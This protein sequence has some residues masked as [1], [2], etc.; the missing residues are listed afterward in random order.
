MSA[1][2]IDLQHYEAVVR[3]N[4]IRPGENWPSYVE[5]ICVIAGG[6]QPG[7]GFLS[8]DT[9]WFDW[10]QTPA[11]GEPPESEPPFRYSETGARLPYRD[12]E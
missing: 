10:K 3:S 1:Q 11:V 6:I 12:S 8:K 9:Q 5:R 7:E 2:V 4:R